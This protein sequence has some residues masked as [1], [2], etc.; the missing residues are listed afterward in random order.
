MV[1]DP[2]SMQFNKSKK[3]KHNYASPDMIH[4]A[5]GYLSN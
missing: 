3:K 5:K 1:I 4:H 2:N